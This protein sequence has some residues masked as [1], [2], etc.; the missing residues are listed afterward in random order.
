M[1]ARGPVAFGVMDELARRYLLLGL[2]LDP[3]RIPA[4]SS[5]SIKADDVA[6]ARRLGG[7]IRQ[8][9]HAGYERATGGHVDYVLAYGGTG[10][11][12]EMSRYAGQLGGYELIYTSQ[13]GGRARLYRRR[14][15]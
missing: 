14:R 11:A 13:P 10:G 1:P 2:R 7:T 4:R 6:H 9:A 5:A 12:P 15:S 3:A 8:L